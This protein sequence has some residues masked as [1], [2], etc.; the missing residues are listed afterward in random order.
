MICSDDQLPPPPES[1]NLMAL[2]NQT[3]ATSV[4]SD[5][6]FSEGEDLRMS[7]GG[8]SDTWRDVGGSESEK[9]L[10]SDPDSNQRKK[11]SVNLSDDLSDIIFLSPHWLLQ[12]MKKIL[13][14][15]LENDIDSVMYHSPPLSLSLSPCVTS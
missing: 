12:S 13:T 11:S 3:S 9:Y 10:R 15:H 14:H 4:Q 6:T 5:V 1:L 7:E 8:E 2:R